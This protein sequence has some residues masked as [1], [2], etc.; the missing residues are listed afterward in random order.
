MKY[1]TPDWN[2]WSDPRGL[3]RARAPRA[4]LTFRPATQAATP[5]P[6]VAPAANAAARVRRRATGDAA[7]PS[8]IVCSFVCSGCQPSARNRSFAITHGCTRYGTTPGGIS[9][10]PSDHVTS[11]RARSSVDARYAGTTDR[12]SN[13]RASSYASQPSHATLNVPGWSS[14]IISSSAATRSST[15]TA[16][17]GG[18]A[19]CTRSVGRPSSNRDGSRSAPGPSTG[20]V[21][22][23][24]DHR[25]GMRVAPLTEQPLGLD[26]LDRG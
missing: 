2:E 16:C 10:I 13:A 9:P 19:P 8:R 4:C 26:G 3:E 1:F 22:K 17:T 12:G 5:A 11:Q 7:T 14:R 21:R 20:A 25:A 18:A 24:G 23:R 6:A 15:W